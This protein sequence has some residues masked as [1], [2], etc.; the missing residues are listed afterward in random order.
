[1]KFPKLFSVLV[2]VVFSLKPATAAVSWLTDLPAAEAQAKAEGKFVLINFTGSD[3]C[4][5]C[6]KLRK[7]VFLKSEFND[8]AKTNLIL[9]E[10]DFPKRKPQPAPL[11]QANQK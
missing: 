1:M 10:V 7:E 4:G 5:W 6:M 3:W 11:Q 8:Y 9:V 2:L